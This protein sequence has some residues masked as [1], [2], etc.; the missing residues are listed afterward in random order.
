MKRSPVLPLFGA[1]LAVAFPSP[2]W[3][4]E[5][6]KPNFVYILADDMGYGDV[7]CLNP[8]GKIATPHMDRLAAEG[9]RFTDA[10]S[11]SSVCTPTRYGILTGRYNWRSR[12]KNGVQGGMS[13]DLI[14]PGRPTVASFLKEQ[15]YRTA[16]FGKWHLGFEWKRKPGTPPFSDGIEKGADGWN[17][18]FSQPFGGGPLRVGFEYYFGI[19][20]SLDMVPYTFLENDRVLATP[21]VDKSFPMTLGKKGGSTRV[22]P[23]AESFEAENVLPEL[24]RRVVDYIRH[25]A[26][27]AKSG[28]PFFIYMPLNS[29]HT[30]ILPSAEWRGKSGISPYADFVMQ[31]DATL[32]AVLDALDQSGLREET[33]VVMTSDNGCSPMADFAGLAQFGHHPSEFRRG[34]K[35]DSFDGGHRVPFLVRWPGQVPAG[36]SYGELVCLNDWFAT[37]ADVVG[38]PLPADGGEDSVSL[39][40]A[41]LGKTREPLRKT[42][43]HHS[44]N[45]SF[46]IREGAFKLLLVPDSGGWSSPKPGSEEARGLPAVQ[47]YDM[48]QDP[49]ETRNLQQ[50]RPE[51]VARLTRLLL[52]EIAEGGTP[53]GKRRA[54]R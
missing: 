24:T 4:A 26:G 54:P 46:A 13:P 35:A 31:T 29:P 40:P 41:L 33:V 20:A 30:P 10:H 28:E 16:C 9:M 1:L 8:A 19:A 21:T 18:D 52:Q 15:G 45:G 32:G 50:E 11:S 25:Q 48:Q 36:G 23:G 51:V 42:L 49:G 12:L 5:S 38:K 44:I 47:L 2:L 34:H 3:T 22:G 17:A 27:A 6:R 39:L 43:V 7:R 14:E 53:S 37:V